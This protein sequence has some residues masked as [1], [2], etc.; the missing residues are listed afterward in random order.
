MQ[1]EIISK[2]LNLQSYR[3]ERRENPSSSSS[4]S[5]FSIRNRFIRD[6]LSMSKSNK[7]F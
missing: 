7:C 3:F 5:S 6:N 2:P 1:K 4:S